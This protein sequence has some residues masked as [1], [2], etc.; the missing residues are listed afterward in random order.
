MSD[1]EHN[2]H[3][4]EE[5]IVEI[6][7]QREEIAAAGSRPSRV[8]MSRQHYDVIQAYRARLGE[9]MSEKIDYLGRYR[10]FDLEICIEELD[11]PVVEAE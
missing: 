8:L 4:A 3:E 9:V 5:L 7:R 2:P 10:L 11:A 1:S 6:Y